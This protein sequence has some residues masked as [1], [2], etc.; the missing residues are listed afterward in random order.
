MIRQQLQRSRLKKHGQYYVE[1][2]QKWLY[3]SFD[4]IKKFFWVKIFPCWRRFQPFLG[5]SSYFI[6]IFLFQVLFDRFR[7]IFFVS[8]IKLLQQSY[9]PINCP[10]T[11]HFRLFWC[12][13]AISGK[14]TLESCPNN[15]VSTKSVNVSRNVRIA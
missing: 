4:S 5:A 7:C 3:R 13:Y 9:K 2:G 12:F 10:K 14:I 6:A 15:N 1:H 11:V 8:Y